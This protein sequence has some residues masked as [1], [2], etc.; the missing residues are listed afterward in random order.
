MSLTKEEIMLCLSKYSTDSNT[1]LCA[2]NEWHAND[3]KINRRTFHNAHNRKELRQIKARN[4]TRVINKLKRLQK[5][6][7]QEVVYEKTEL[8]SEICELLSEYAIG[9]F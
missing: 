5:A 4:L 9:K 1:F 7:I 3:M 8:P 6:K 2:Y